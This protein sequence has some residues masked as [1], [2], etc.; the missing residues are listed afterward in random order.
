M[1]THIHRLA[2]RWGLTLGGTVEQT[3]ADLKAVFP[4]AAWNRVHLQ[5]RR[6]CTRGLEMRMEIN[7]LACMAT[8]NQMFLHE[9]SVWLPCRS[10]TSAASTAR[11]SGTT[12]PSA[13]S[14]VG[15][16]TRRRACAAATFLW[17]H[18]CYVDGHFMPPAQAGM[19]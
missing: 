15:P 8:Q 13:P 6:A 16:P 17:Q 14:A 5:V 11:R 7:I 18:T 9:T 10:C 1:D 12:P 2:K 3:E 4:E 19:S